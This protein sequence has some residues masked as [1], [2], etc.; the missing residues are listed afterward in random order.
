M[1]IIYYFLSIERQR[2]YRE[3]FHVPT[4]AHP[5]S[6]H[7]H[8]DLR[9][10]VTVFILIFQR[11]RINW[12]DFLPR[13]CFSACLEQTFSLP[14][15]NKIVSLSVPWPARIVDGALEG[16]DAPR[17]HP[18]TPIYCLDEKSREEKASTFRR[19]LFINFIILVSL[20]GK[21]LG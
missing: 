20:I 1:E 12:C 19:T 11:D 15:C 17:G 14:G 8:C 2:M 18:C 16:N 13:H 4:Y 6:C 3:T 9:F 21:I 7:L 10:P 5:L